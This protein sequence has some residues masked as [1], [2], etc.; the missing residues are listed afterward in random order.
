MHLEVHASYLKKR[1][2]LALTA[3]RQWEGSYPSVLF[4]SGPG[5]KQR[6]CAGSSSP[7]QSSTQRSKVRIQLLLPLHPPVYPS[8]IFFM[9]THTIELKT[10]S[11][12]PI[13][14][15]FLRH[16]GPG[17]LLSCKCRC[18]YFH[19]SFV[20]FLN[21]GKKETFISIREINNLFL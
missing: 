17:R 14:W 6:A 4:P 7:R 1:N 8:V 20:G 12:L 18:L 3:Q 10:P 16:P 21:V 11:A 13:L 19:L 15:L 9:T 2:A 5:L